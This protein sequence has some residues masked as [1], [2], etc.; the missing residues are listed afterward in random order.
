[1]AISISARVRTAMVGLSLGLCLL[2]GGLIFLLV[3]VIEDQVFVNQ[4]NVERAAFA[5]TIAEADPDAIKRWQPAN[6][7]I[8]RLDSIAGLPK[9]LSSEALKRIVEQRGIH[10]Y[11]DDVN[12]LFVASLQQPESGQP[13]YLV[14]DVQRLLVVRN[15][16]GRLLALI[17]GL[18][19]VI[20][21]ASVLLARWLAKATLA[22][23]SR[24]SR[25]L[26][27]HDLDQA[28]IELA[29]EFSEDEIGVL[30]RELAQ[31]LER[32]RAAAQREYEFNRGVSH[33]LRSP[34]QV[35]QSATELM[36]LYVSKNDS[37]MSKPVARLQ[38]AVVEM[39][40]VADAFLWLASDRDR[41]PDQACSVAALEDAIEPVQASF[42]T[43]N[44]RIVKAVEEPFDYPMP[45]TVLSVVLRNLVRN[46]VMHGDPSLIKVDLQLDR[47]CVSNSVK[48]SEQG[49]NSFGM[50]LSIVQRICDRFDCELVT[51]RE[52]DGRYS[53]SIVFVS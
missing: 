19:F 45:R 17:G 27:E 26:Q 44:I 13:Y 43:Y 2:F 11:F 48:S 20:A 22:P 52:G 38:R 6:A 24:L 3:Y 1:M 42:P 8:K 21:I 4:I 16:K 46:A 18:A 40:E 33:E 31:A 15:S 53:S 35:A 49:G 7:N 12:A 5:Q 36:Q 32:V 50:G 39:N 51:G 37:V 23:V 9:T 30:T 25:A 14:Y 29:N 34:I 41:K 10:E 47:I 28:V